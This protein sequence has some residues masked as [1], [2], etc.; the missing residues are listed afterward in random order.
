MTQGHSWTNLSAPTLSKNG[1]RNISCFSNQRPPP[2]SKHPEFASIC[3]HLVSRFPI[4]TSAP[5]PI[6]P[7]QDITRID[8][9]LDF[10]FP[11]VTTAPAFVRWKFILHFDTWRSCACLKLRARPLGVTILRIG[12]PRCSNCILLYS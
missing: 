2:K 10:W 6:L 11:D 3:I 1:P 4:E 12:E 7:A 9:V 5:A 8:H